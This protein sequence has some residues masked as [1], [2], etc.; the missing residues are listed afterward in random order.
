MKKKILILH[1]VYEHVGGAE[2]YI[3]EISKSLNKEFDVYKISQSFNFENKKEKNIVYQNKILNKFQK[4]VSYYLFD[5]KFYFFL[6]KQLKKIQP[7]LIH[8]HHNNIH[9]FP[10]LKII[11]K[12]KTIQTIHDYGLLCPN[13]GFALDKNNNYCTNSRGLRCLNGCTPKRNIIFLLP[14][15]IKKILMKK[16]IKLFIAPSKKLKEGMIKNGFKNTTLLNYFVN[17]NYLKV[18]NSKKF[19]LKKKKLL[20]V[21]GLTQHKGIH[22]LLEAI[23]KLPP[24]YKKKVI[25]DIVG[26]GPYEKNLLELINKLRLGEIVYIRGH[27]EGKDLQ[28]FY[29]KAYSLI[30]PSLWVEQFGIVGLEAMAKGTPCIGSNRGG[31]PEWI[32]DKEDGLLFNPGDSDDLKNKIE[33]FLNNPKI[34]EKFGKNAQQKI[35][36][37]FLKKDHIEKLIKLYYQIINE[38]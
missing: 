13:G 8:L 9:P 24:E 27:K 28:R 16:N 32:K 20:Y 37:N 29:H 12:Y 1:D 34:V 26:S 3:E 33:Y 21:G 35:K 4:Y 31:I 23:S 10:V 19:Y 22:I 2:T 38:R 11:K 15:K 36:Q 6:L 17:E 18:Q 14:L 25:L 5:W 30:V 7:D